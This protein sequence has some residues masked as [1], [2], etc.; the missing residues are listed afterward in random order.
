MS[1]F[2]QGQFIQHP[3]SG[4]VILGL[5]LDP[6]T[7]LEKGD[8]YNAGSGE[9]KPYSPDSDHAVAIVPLHN[10]AIIWV[11]L[12]K[13]SLHG[14]S[15]CVLRVLYLH[16][17]MI[18]DCDGGFI[19]EPSHPRVINPH[20]KKELVEELVSFG[21]INLNDGLI[22]PAGKRLVEILH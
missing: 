22:T 5:K 8:L 12:W 3:I 20:V 16:K 4:D 13:G 14:E 1:P 18:R 17:L 19:M 9:W 2:I 21:F 15:L 11:R 10:E 7:Q 6:G